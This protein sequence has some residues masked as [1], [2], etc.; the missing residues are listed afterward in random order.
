M[1]A[2]PP[3]AVVGALEH[4]S[5][6]VVGSPSGQRP[7]PFLMSS[8]GGLLVRSSTCSVL[9]ARE[10]P[11]RGTDVLA[12]V[13][14]RS[15]RGVLAAAGDE[16]TAH[17]CDLRVLH[18]V[19]DEALAAQAVRTLHE[20]VRAVVPVM[21]RTTVDVVVGDVRQVLVRSARDVG[22][23]VLGGRRAL[24]LSDLAVA[25]VTAAV[26][27]AAPVPLLVVR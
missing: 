25:S 5:L 14:L 15:A 6:L 9:V 8:T 7:V 23:L 19:Q 12:A 20:V 22:L 13:D 17:R 10:A 11:P 27:R 26:L 18:V 4:C 2:D 16:A 24:A 3:A 1:A 21:T